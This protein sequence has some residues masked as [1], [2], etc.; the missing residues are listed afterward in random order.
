[1]VGTL[2]GAVIDRWNTARLLTLLT[3]CQA[4]VLLPLLLLG[5]GRLWIV[6]AVAGAEAAITS[7][8]MPAQ[9]ALVPALV[10][11]QQLPRANAIVQMASN[12][13]RLAGSP[14]GGLLLPAVGL[15]VL[16]LGDAA[17]FLIAGACLAGCRRATRRAPASHRREPPGRLGAVA[18]G[19][20][21][22]R[23]NRTLAS[24]L[25]ISC[26]S[27]IAQGMFLV[28]FVLF[29]LRSMHAGDQVVGLLRGVQAIGGVLGG[30]IV[31]TW[32][33]RLGARALAI[34]GLGLFGSISMLTWN[35]P[36]ITTATW[37]YIGLFVAV[38][39]PGTA[40]L[41]GLLTGAQHA[42]PPHAIGRVLSLI[43]VAEAL[44]QGAGILAAGLLAGSVSLTILLNVQASLYLA[45]ALL[46][47]LT[48]VQADTTTKRTAPA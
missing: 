15:N 34:G 30:L 11:S 39:L 44:G 31:G 35:S 8:A 1:V 42:S 4:A 21:A 3:S 16:V 12:T 46:A 20:T 33:K 5:P 37:W 7:I 40:L 43:Q 47:T 38:G 24:A 45:C 9:Q 29:V 6:Y 28:L 2:C 36:T 22:L 23:R 41:T 32:A 27:A 17:S 18:E 26:L 19:W 48:F 14:L 13:A 10:S 25:V